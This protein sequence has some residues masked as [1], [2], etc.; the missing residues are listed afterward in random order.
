[1][2][3]FSLFSSVIQESEAGA[4]LD[5]N[6]IRFYGGVRAAESQSKEGKTEL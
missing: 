1:M 3:S 5:A 4:E 6:S 2:G